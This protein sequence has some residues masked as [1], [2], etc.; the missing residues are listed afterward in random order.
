MI[1]LLIRT[2]QAI[3]ILTWLR[4]VLRSAQ[5]ESELLKGSWRPPVEKRVRWQDVEEARDKLDAI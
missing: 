1:V 4:S 3:G 5:L 2:L